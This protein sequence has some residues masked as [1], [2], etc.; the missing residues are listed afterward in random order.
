MHATLEA[1]F[2]ECQ[3]DKKNRTL[4]RVDKLNHNF[5]LLIVSKVKPDFTNMISQLNCLSIKEAWETKDYAPFLIKIKKG[6]LW[7]FRLRA[8]PT[9]NHKTAKGKRGKICP[10]LTP[11]T[12]NKWLSDKAKISGF[13]TDSFIITQKEVKEFSRKGKKVTINM[14]TY[15]GLLRVEDVETFMRTLTDGI[16]R[17]KAYGCGLLTIVKE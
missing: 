7:H 4:W 3:P 14:V 6:Q 15:E 10:Y 11:E 16:G 17:A 12:Q 13:S 2:P 1:S 5:Y 9:L 8:N